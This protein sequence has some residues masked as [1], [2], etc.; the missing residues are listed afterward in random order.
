MN[1][2]GKKC[3]QKYF[4]INFFDVMLLDN[5]DNQHSRM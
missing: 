4:V 5:D 1:K 2:D 3:D